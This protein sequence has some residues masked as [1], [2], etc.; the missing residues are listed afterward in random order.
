MTHPSPAVPRGR[1]VPGDRSAPPESAILRAARPAGPRIPV[2]SAPTVRADAPRRRVPPAP[3]RRAALHRVGAGGLAAAAGLLLAGLLLRPA[4][5]GAAVIHVVDAAGVCGG[6]APCYATIQAAVDA[7]RAGDTVRVQE[8]LYVEQ[9]MVARKNDTPAAVE[10]DRLTIE[11]DPEAPAGSV[12]LQGASRT[13]PGGEAVRIHQS[14]FVTL[15]GLTITGAGGPGI[16]LEGQPRANSAIRLERNRVV[17]NGPGGCAGGIAVGRGNRDILIV[18]NAIHDN[19]R[20]GVAGA[21]G[22]RSYLVGNTIHGNAWNG[23]SLARRHEALL[24]NN[25]ITGNGRAAGSAG[26]RVGILRDAPGAAE[27]TTI[28]LLSNLVCGNRLGELSGAMLDPGDAGN[29][30]PTGTEGPGVTAA[31]GCGDPDATYAAA[32]GPDGLPGTLDDDFRPAS[33]SVLIDRGIDPRGLGLGAW[34]D[35]LVEADLLGPGARPSPGT[36]GGAAR[37]DIGAVEFRP[38]PDTLAPTVTFRAPAAG[39]LVRGAIDVEA[40]AADAG[41]GVASLTLEADGRP[42]PAVRSPAAPAPI[43]RASGV[44]STAG[45]PDGAHTLTAVA[46]DQAGL[47]A[48][49][50]RVV[51]TDN[52]PPV[53][54]I[55]SGPTGTI[56]SREARFTLT[57]TDN[58]TPPEQLRAMWRLDDGPWSPVPADLAVTLVELPA[59]PHRFEATAQD[60][61]GN[62]SPPAER[63]FTVAVA[64]LTIT[65]PAPYAVIEGGI[66]LVRGTVAAE[67][68]EVSV[69]VNGTAATVHEGAFATLIPVSTATSEVVGVATTSAGATATDS[70]RVSVVDPVE[71]ALVLHA[72]PRSGVAPLT[73]TLWVLGAP[74]G[75]PIE[76]DLDGDGLS[77]RTG[78]SLGGEVVIYD[79]PGLYAPTAA[80]TDARGIRRVARALVHVADRTSLDTLLQAKWTGLKD[81]LRAADIPQALAHISARARVRY[82]EAFRAIARRLSGIDAIL[83]DLTLDAIGNGLAIYQAARTDRGV[84]RLFEVRFAVGDDGLWRLDSF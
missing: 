42:I 22:A 6:R 11:A 45:V 68:P 64:Q 29:V 26:G 62:E 82:D 36:P 20:D 46:V 50:T 65:E 12:V 52:T 55:T 43:L 33:G 76:L 70:V 15:R 30:T 4:P 44:W 54:E 21:D 66:L 3:A 69:R 83:T 5:G 28:R 63:R 73:V 47:A 34:L 1:A 81:A 8:G 67:D 16:A 84:P 35:P 78:S 48:S 59:G 75:A 79:R 13:C 10:T 25:A 40:E 77:D 72:T 7:A 19:G 80:F 37:F 9:L 32:T 56:G 49:A 31:P 18:N 17:G 61:A 23:V 60:G 24:A 51:I 2:P 74:P 41:S 58:L 53:V 39:A 57:L 71:P 27:R 38:P 14:S